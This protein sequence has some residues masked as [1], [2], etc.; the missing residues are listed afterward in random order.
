MIYTKLI[1]WKSVHF[2]KCQFLGT[3]D[4]EAVPT[5]Y[6]V[7]KLSGTY[8]TTIAEVDLFYYYCSLSDSR[9]DVTSRSNTARVEFLGKL[10]NM[11]KL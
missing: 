9:T 4:P 7:K 2:V 6:D 11:L 3:E 8:T 5:N 10:I 1:A